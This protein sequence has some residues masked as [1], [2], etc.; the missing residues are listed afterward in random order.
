MVSINK[1]YGGSRCLNARFSWAKLVFRYLSEY[2]NDCNSE[3][4]SGD[5]VRETIYPQL[6]GQLEGTDE[7]EINELK[8][9]SKKVR[10]KILKTDYRLK[11]KVVIGVSPY[12]FHRKGFNISWYFLDLIEDDVE[13]HLSKKSKVINSFFLKIKN[14]NRA[15]QWKADFL[16]DNKSSELKGSLYVP[17]Y[18][19]ESRF[20]CE[21]DMHVN[22]D[23]YHKSQADNGYAYG[24]GY[25]DKNGTTRKKRL[26]IIINNI[27]FD[28]L[29]FPLFDCVLMNRF[30]KSFEIAEV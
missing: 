9:K 10:K 12:D 14:E 13:F 8:K 24:Y 17:S 28:G 2:K 25:R 20:V 26:D 18:V 29:H 11:R 21:A 1:S 3:L 6:S 16:R 15:K 22:I 4:L 23:Y 27:E 30:T 5:A 7:F 19:P